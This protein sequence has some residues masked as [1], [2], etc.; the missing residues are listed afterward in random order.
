MEHDKE[1]DI[2]D[3]SDDRQV[4]QLDETPLP[5]EKPLKAGSKGAEIQKYLLDAGIEKRKVDRLLTVLNV[6]QIS[7]FHHFFIELPRNKSGY[8]LHIAANKQAYLEKSPK[9]GFLLDWDSIGTFARKFHHAKLDVL[10]ASLIACKLPRTASSTKDVP[11]KNVLETLNNLLSYGIDDLP[12]ELV[13]ILEKS[14]AN[15]P[16]KLRDH[17]FF[18]SLDWNQKIRPVEMGKYK[19]FLNKFKIDYALHPWLLSPTSLELNALCTV[20]IDAD[21]VKLE[22]IKTSVSEEITWSSHDQKVVIGN[23]K[24]N[25]KPICSIV[26]RIGE[27]GSS[28][29]RL[30]TAMFCPLL[31]AAQAGNPGEFDL[32][33][34]ADTASWLVANAPLREYSAQTRK[35]LDAFIPQG[36]KGG[37]ARKFIDLA[38]AKGTASTTSTATTTSTAKPKPQTH[39]QTAQ[40]TTTS[41]STTAR[42]P[43]T[44]SGTSSKRS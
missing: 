9:G 3:W 33:L 7:S 10:A 32:E 26:E 8:L 44:N 30:A 20:Y 29:P 23:L 22:K 5:P 14:R 19:E 21:G 37:N 18:K 34:L 25:C 13:N 28:G 15:M 38:K 35:L 24:R 17:E 39:T 43:T 41:T 31:E 1:F 27:C 4:V 16:E 2:I 11:P 40:G 36:E 6:D 12:D 42:S